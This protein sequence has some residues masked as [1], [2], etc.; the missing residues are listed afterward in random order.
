MVNTVDCAIISSLSSMNEKGREGDKSILYVVTH[1]TCSHL[2]HF[3]LIC[4]NDSK[5]CN[6]HLT[7]TTVRKEVQKKDEG[8]KGVY[9]LYTHINDRRFLIER[10]GESI[11]V[12]DPFIFIVY[13]NEDLQIL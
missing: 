10:E 3:S 7:K 4:D 5:Y 2:A 11:G 8:I 1:G 13:T 12:W 6:E 9:T